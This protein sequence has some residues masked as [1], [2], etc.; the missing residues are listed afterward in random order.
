M[1]F[2]Q[3]VNRTKAECGISGADLTTVVGATK[4][5]GRLVGWVSQAYVEIQESSPDLEW[6]RKPFSFD[7]VAQQQSY[8][9]STDMLLTDFGMFRNGSFRIYL[10]SAGVANEIFLNQLDYTQFRDYYMYG[11]RQITYARP[12]NIAI[13]PAKDLVLGLVPDTVYTVNGEYYINPVV[14]AADADTPAMPARY[15]MAIVYKAMMKYGMFESAQEQV[16]TGQQLYSEV[17]NKMNF[18]Q[19]PTLLS[20]APFI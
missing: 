18:D 16:T 20:A 11:T 8:D 17:M 15:H 9:A 7:T 12:T 6:M 14:L 5:L 10:K 3:L 19:S 1:N 13:T 4:E 2:L